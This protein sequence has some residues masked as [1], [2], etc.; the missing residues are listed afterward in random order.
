MTQRVPFPS[1]GRVTSFN[2]S[3]LD[4]GGLVVE[5]FEIRN[6]LGAYNRRNGEQLAGK[7]VGPQNPSSH[8]SFVEPANLSGFPL[9]KV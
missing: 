3:L 6:I 5:D 4:T 8:T 1:S 7:G 9:F 2:A